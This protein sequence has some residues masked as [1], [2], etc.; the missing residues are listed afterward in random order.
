MQTFKGA[1]D[2]ILTYFY[3]DLDYIP[4]QYHNVALYEGIVV[5]IVIIVFWPN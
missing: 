2:I 3:C 5:K 4:Y 1:Y